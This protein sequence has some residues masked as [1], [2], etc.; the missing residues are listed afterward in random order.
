MKINRIDIVT[1]S[2][3]SLIGLYLFVQSPAPLADENQTKGELISVNTLFNIVAEENNKAR[4]Q[5]TKQIVGAGKKVGLKFGENW[6]KQH[7]DKGPLPALFL[8]EVATHLEKSEVSLSLFLG[9]DFPIS[10]AN[11]FKGR[12]AEAFQKIRD[13]NGETQY[14]FAEDVKRY[15]AM[16]PDNVMVKACASCHNEHPDSPKKDWVMNNIMGAT[17]WAYPREYVT[18][19]ELI[20]IVAEL[21]SA[22]AK[23]YIS[24]LEKTKT[25]ENAPKIGEKW[26]FE[27][28]LIPAADVFMERLE[29]A[30]SVDTLRLILNKMDPKITIDKV[31]HTDNNEN[32]KT[33]NAERLKTGAL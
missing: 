21:R 9:S 14:F 1:L 13:T 7:V 19:D 18:R 25:F 12:Q 17:T 20:Q 29:N 32:K 22:F 11:K 8:R 24:Y 30:A 28:Y 3:L 6:R 31:T 15:T 33:A 16:F 4:K 27:G 23:T 2:I 10:S 5:W 26:P